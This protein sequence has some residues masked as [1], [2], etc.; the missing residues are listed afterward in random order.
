MNAAPRPRGR[1]RKSAAERDEGNRRLALVAA[2]GRLFRVHGFAA[3]RT[4]D[5]A[6]AV[7]M[8]SGSPFY[9][10]ARKEDLLVAVMEQGMVGALQLQRSALCACGPVS[11]PAQRLQALL[12]SH[13]EVIHGPHSDFIPVMLYEWRHVP[14]RQAQRIAHLRRQYEL[15]F[16]PVLHALRCEGRLRGE[17]R[18]ARL[19]LLGALNWS[20]QWFDPRGP[21]GLDALTAEVMALVLG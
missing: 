1:P 6:A 13:F 10:F 5:I 21:L 15:A 18:L 16:L 3:T 12:R 8:R 11:T 17:V 2:A 9:H 4:R 19:F 14:A 20:V 7:G